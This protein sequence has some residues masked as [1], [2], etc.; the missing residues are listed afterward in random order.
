MNVLTFRVFHQRP[1]FLVLIFG[2]LSSDGM[3]PY[4]AGSI[5]RFFIVPV[6]MLGMV[7]I[8][9]TVFIPYPIVPIPFILLALL[10]GNF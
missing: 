2:S 6:K 3:S 8:L 7:G 4:S 9:L 1:I 10:A 5:E